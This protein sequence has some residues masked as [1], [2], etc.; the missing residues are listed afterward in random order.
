MEII[1]LNTTTPWGSI[2][3]KPTTYPPAA[4]SHLDESEGFAEP[5]LANYVGQAIG[6][7]AL[8]QHTHPPHKGPLT[9]NLPTGLAA[10]SPL[11]FLS[12]NSLSKYKVYVC[13][14]IVECG[15][16]PPYSGAGA[17]VFAP[18]SSNGV[19]ASL[20][21]SLIM[22]TGASVTATLKATGGN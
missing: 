2:T 10:N 1:N 14:L 20:S 21:F 8:T 18:T 3:N 4:H 13:K 6:S 7:R 9:V 17:I 5:W 19:N 16:Q 12:A 22:H 15:A 11:L